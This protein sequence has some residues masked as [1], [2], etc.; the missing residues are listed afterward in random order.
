MPQAL[1]IPHRRAIHT[2]ARSSESQLRRDLK[3][4]L[5]REQKVEIL[6]WPAAQFKEWLGAPGEKTEIYGEGGGLL[7]NAVVNERPIVAEFKKF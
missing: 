1:T 5:D 6:G 2:E 7:L 3:D 4:Q